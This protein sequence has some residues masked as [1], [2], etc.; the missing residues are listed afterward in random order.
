MQ[1]HLC[2]SIFVPKTIK[3]KTSLQQ[4][5]FSTSSTILTDIKVQRR[6]LWSPRPNDRRLHNKITQFFFQNVKKIP[7][8]AA[9]TAIYSR[10]KTKFSKNREI[11]VQW[12]LWI[13]E[14]RF[15]QSFMFGVLA[16]IAKVVFVS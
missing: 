10:H 13:F 12:K 1:I 15:R 11:W 4:W 6:A 8:L 2:G 9:I 3:H 16:K 7:K 5:V 14:K